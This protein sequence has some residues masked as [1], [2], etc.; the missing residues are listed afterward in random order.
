LTDTLEAARKALAAGGPAAAEPL[1][2][3]RLEQAPLDAEALS[4]GQVW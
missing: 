2:V 4:R 3:A 1:L